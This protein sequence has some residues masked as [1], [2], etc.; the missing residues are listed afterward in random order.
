M[1][2]LIET[3]RMLGVSVINQL[4]EI[5]SLENLYF[6]SLE[7]DKILNPALFRTGELFNIHFSKLPAYKGM[8]TSAWPILNG[9]DKTGVT[10]HKIDRGIDTGEIID[11]IE[12]PIEFADTCRDLYFKYNRFGCELF[13]SNICN[14]LSKQY[15]ARPQSWYGSSYYSKASID[16]GCIKIDLNKTAFEIHNQIR[17]FIFPEYQ[18]PQIHGCSIIGSEILNKASTFKAGHL[19]EEKPEFMVIATIDYDL[20]LFKKTS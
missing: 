20:K 4:S 7:Y 14:I 5:Y 9:E 19:V 13:K 18:L 2:D 1:K 8:Y 15:T 12:F 6:F 17:A 16:Y 10:L 3:A 11:Q